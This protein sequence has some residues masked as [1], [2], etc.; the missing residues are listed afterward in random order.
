MI[1][2]LFLVQTR[3]HSTTNSS[4]HSEHDHMFLFFIIFL[5]SHILHLLAYDQIFLRDLINQPH[6]LCFWYSSKMI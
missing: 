6:V 1:P 4:L 2:Q 3:I 5:C